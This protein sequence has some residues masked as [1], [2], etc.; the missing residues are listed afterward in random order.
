[1]P[2]FRC[3]T[4]DLQR[5]GR[6]KGSLSWPWPAAATWRLTLRRRSCR[7]LSRWAPLFSSWIKHHAHFSE[8]LLRVTS[9]GS[10]TLFARLDYVV[11]V[12]V[13]AI[14]PSLVLVRKDM[15]L[16]CKRVSLL[17]TSGESI[18]GAKFADENFQL[19]ARG[20]HSNLPRPQIP[21][22]CATNMAVHYD[23]HHF[24]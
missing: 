6:A 3:S 24:F 4:V 10:A 7:R 9:I 17:A 5:I 12:S 22:S 19:K 8:A 15:V 20:R 2:L 21:A 13:P 1:M 16:E 14:A 11:H 18:Y 23:V